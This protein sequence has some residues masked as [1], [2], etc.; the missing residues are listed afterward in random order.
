MKKLFLIRHAKSSWANN[1]LEDFERPLNNRGKISADFMGKKLAES[2]IKPDSIIS[3]PA[4][5]TQRTSERIAQKVSY[6]NIDIH[7]FSELY[8]GDV[9]DYLSVI[10]DVSDEHECIFIVGHNPG[11]TVFLDYLCCE[12]ADMVTCAIAEIEFDLNSWA[13]VSR[14]TG[15]LKS[16]SYPKKYDEFKALLNG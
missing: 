12:F 6:P 14:K 13:E 5:R 16:F 9:K 4:K 15:M 11:I 8:L 3:S 10:N 7:Y 1:D 2:G